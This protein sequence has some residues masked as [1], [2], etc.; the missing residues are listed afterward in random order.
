MPQSW[1]HGNSPDAFERGMDIEGC[2]ACWP[3]SLMG[4]LHLSR[5]QC[6]PGVGRPEGERDPVQTVRPTSVWAWP[7][8][9]PGSL[10]GEISSLRAETLPVQMALVCQR[11]LPWKCYWAEPCVI[12]EGASRQLDPPEPLG[13]TPEVPWSRAF[14]F[15]L[16][17]SSSSAAGSTMSG[18]ES[19]CK[20]G[21]GDMEEENESPKAVENTNIWEEIVWSFFWLMHLGCAGISEER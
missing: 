6:Q 9:G 12:S 5:Q 1:R 13:Q 16:L 11:W 21:D 19:H 2:V 18:R 4:L 14:S 7:A 3:G 10:P 15:N 20:N 8:Q 17:L